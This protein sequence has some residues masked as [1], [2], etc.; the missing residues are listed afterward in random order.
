[1][2]DLAYEADRELVLVNFKALVRPFE[3]ERSALKAFQR[4]QAE[5]RRAKVAKM[6]DRAQPL[7]LRL[8][9]DDV[10]GSVSGGRRSEERSGRGGMQLRV[11][12]WGGGGKKMF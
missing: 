4:Q 2:S 1:M 8:W 11:R 6:C 7:S 9:L 12:T 5:L 10:R 3:S